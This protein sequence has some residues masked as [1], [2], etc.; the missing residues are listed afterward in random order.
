MGAKLAQRIV[1]E[2]KD[3]VGT[4]MPSDALDMSDTGTPGGISAAGNAAEAVSALSVLGFTPGEASAAVG[5]LD[6][7]LPV[8][9]LVRE[10]LKALGKR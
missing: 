1:L 8:E 7:T 4:L 9:T 2:M 3:K 6:S 5:K 10:A